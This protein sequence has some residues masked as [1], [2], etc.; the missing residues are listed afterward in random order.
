LFTLGL[1]KYWPRAGAK[2]RLS[3]ILEGLLPGGGANHRL[4]EVTTTALNSSQDDQDV[5]SNNT[6]EDLEAPKM[7]HCFTAAV[8]GSGLGF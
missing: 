5:L 8:F 1:K 4:G 7:N 2:L 6:L 3:Q